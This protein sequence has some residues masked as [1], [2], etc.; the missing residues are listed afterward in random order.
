MFPSFIRSEDKDQEVC[1]ASS[2]LNTFAFRCRFSG[3][4]ASLGTMYLSDHMT[5]VCALQRKRREEERGWEAMK[6]REVACLITPDE[7]KSTKR[8]ISKPFFLGFWTCYAIFETQI[9]T[10]DSFSRPKP[11]EKGTKRI[12]R[13][14]KVVALLPLKTS[15]SFENDLYLYYQAFFWCS[16]SCSGLW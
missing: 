2:T 14:E 9:A 4:C 1:L 7:S 10:N 16:T 8:T 15:P 12:R 5:Y 13:E 3:C 6:K 11:Q